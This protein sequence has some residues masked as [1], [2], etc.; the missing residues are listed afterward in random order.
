MIYS[1]FIL[2]S[3][4]S[5]DGF[6]SDTINLTP[7]SEIKPSMSMNVFRLAFVQYHVEIK[8]YQIIPV[9]T[10]FI[11]GHLCLT[12]ALCIISA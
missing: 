7:L 8:Y 3:L 1:T 12:N 11:R 2:T 5:S 4:N 9:F 6:V 10:T